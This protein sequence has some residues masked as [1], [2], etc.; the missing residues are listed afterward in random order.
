MRRP[1]LVEQCSWLCLRGHS[2]DRSA[3]NFESGGSLDKRP[4]RDNAAA[5]SGQGCAGATALFKAN[6]KQ[7][8]P[9]SSVRAS[10]P[11][12]VTHSTSLAS[13]AK[14]CTALRA[15]SP[16]LSPS[17]SACVRSRASRL[18]SPSASTVSSAKDGVSKRARM[19]PSSIAP[20]RQLTRCASAPSKAIPSIAAADAL[21]QVIGDT[22]R[23]ELIGQRPTVMLALETDDV[24][25]IARL[26]RLRGDFSRR[27]N[28][29]RLFELWRGLTARA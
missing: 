15:N 4:G 3:R 7:T 5:H 9:G 27:E 24:E 20:S 28:D 29:H 19:S 18:R 8:E 26:D 25:A 12:I 13:A 10:A 22:I 6:F 11:I 16:R 1:D 14:R 23:D 2:P 21:A 17:A